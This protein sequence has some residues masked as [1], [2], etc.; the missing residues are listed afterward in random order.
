MTANG[1]LQIAVFTLAV[2]LVTKPLGLYL[3]AVYEGR[4]RWLAAVERAFYRV[5]GVDPAEEQHW[6]RYAAGMLVFSAASMLLTYAILRLQHVLPLNPQGLGAVT[7]RQAFETAA[8]FTTNTD[9]QSYAGEVD[10]VVPVADDAARGPQLHLRRR[11]HGARRGAGPG[12]RAPF[13]GSTGQL[14]GGPR[15]RH[16]LRAAAALAAPRTR[17]WRSRA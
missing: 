10:D 2:L 9:W 16:A 17:S 8:S 13:G 12:H 11:R 7:D 3:V 1:W 4:V 14:L 6:T 5:A 15:P